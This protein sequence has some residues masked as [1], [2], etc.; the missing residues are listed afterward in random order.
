MSKNNVEQAR[1]HHLNDKD[2]Q[3]GAYVLYWMQ[4]SQRAEFNPALEFAIQRGNEL[5]QPVLVAFGLMDDYPDANLRHYFF[6]LQGLRETRQTLEKRN[7][8]LIVEKGNPADVAVNYSKNASLVVCDKGYQRH[9]K[10]WREKVSKDVN[11]KAFEVEGDVVVPVNVVSDKTEYAAR[12]I[13]PK[14][15]HHMEEFLQPLSDQAPGKS[16]LKFNN[17]GLDL[18]DIDHVLD[19][20][21]LDRSVKPVP[22]FFT[23]GTSE[24]KKRLKK[25]LDK[26]L[27]NY[28]KN[29]NKPETNDT[30]HMSMYLHFG[31]ISPVYI[32]LEVLKQNVK[33]DIESY[34]EELVV[35]R[36]LAVNYVHFTKDYDSYKSIPEWAKKTLQN[37]RDDHRDHIY[38]L[39][40]LENAET[41]DPYWNASM[42]EMKY[43][44]YMHNYMRM[45]W[46]KKILEWTNTPEYGFET[47]LYINNKYFLDGRDCNSYTNISWIYGTHDHGWPER[48]VYGKVRSMMVSGLKRKFNPD[49]Y[50]EKVNQL[51]EKTKEVR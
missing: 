5:N 22:Q 43:T 20:L 38:T 50:V 34:I 9:Q 21:K 10:K 36:E 31:Q 42:N 51:V 24:A 35:R 33:E 6:M 45:Y 41:H 25:F 11:C 12:T 44:G 46:G 19:Q 39:S 13:R 26:S 28:N 49:A 47:T 8:K 1:I 7:I 15:H 30:S 14:I 18:D 17:S 27:T 37:H 48:P 29:R 23:G 2:I 32:I 4:Q 16:S 40:Q 3:S